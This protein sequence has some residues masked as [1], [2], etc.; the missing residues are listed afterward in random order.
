MCEYS[1]KFREFLSKMQAVCHINHK[2]NANGCEAKELF[3][4]IGSDIQE[5]AEEKIEAKKEE[6]KERALDEFQRKLLT[7][8][9]TTKKLQQKNKRITKIQT[10]TIEAERKVRK[11]KETTEEIEKGFEQLKD[12]WTMLGKFTSLLKLIWSKLDPVW[13]ALNKTYKIVLIRKL[14]KKHFEFEFVFSSH[15]IIPLTY[16]F[17]CLSTFLFPYFT[18]Y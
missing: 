12:V 15:Y 11:I 4:N 17:F 3:N 10:K 18:S 7:E 5:Y 1:A 13:K 9:R 2:M 14:C 16:R 6:L 8:K